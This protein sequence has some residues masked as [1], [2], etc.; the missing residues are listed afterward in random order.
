MATTLEHG[1]RDIYRPIDREVLRVNLEQDKLKEAYK[2]I[3]NFH[4][5][6]DLAFSNRL[7]MYQDEMGNQQREEVRELKDEYNAYMTDFTRPA[8]KL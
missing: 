5:V 2:L 3:E 8:V 4:E 1:A 7:F 6:T